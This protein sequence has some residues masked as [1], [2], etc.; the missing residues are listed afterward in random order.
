MQC[1]TGGTWRWCGFIENMK[2]ESP[3]SMLQSSSKRN[4]GDAAIHQYA[5]AARKAARLAAGPKLAA[6][7]AARLAAGPKLAARKAARLAAGPKLAAREAARLAAG[8]K[9]AARKVARLA[10]GPKLAAREAARLAAGPK[11]SAPGMRPGWP[12]AP[13]AECLHRRFSIFSSTLKV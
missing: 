1:W 4:L 7:E 3:S 11:K 5:L 13:G 10:A 6:R 8:P 9:L 2:F 12:R